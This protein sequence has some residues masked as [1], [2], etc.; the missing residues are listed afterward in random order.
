V[1]AEQ[2][3]SL[4]EYRLGQARETLREAEI[5]YEASALRGVVNR[6]YYSMF[7]ALLAL[8]DECTFHTTRTKAVTAT[9]TH[10]AEVGSARTF[11]FCT[12]LNH[13]AMSS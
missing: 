1:N 8:L 7:Y 9:G 11:S 2:L 10:P 12:T 13:L 6:S 5:L 3:E 4:L